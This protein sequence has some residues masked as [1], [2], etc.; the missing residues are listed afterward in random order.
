MFHYNYFL[1]SYTISR[2][3][4]ILHFYF[5]YNSYFIIIIIVQRF[6]QA[7]GFYALQ[8]KFI[9]IIIIII[10]NSSVYKWLYIKS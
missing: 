8:N 7:S 2:F 4:I 10:I 9:I 1:L 3:K 5:L 6:E